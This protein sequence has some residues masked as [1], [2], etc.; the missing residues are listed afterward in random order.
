MKLPL[1]KPLKVDEKEIT[2]LLF[3]FDKL[4]G[5]DI[6]NATDEA[7]QIKGYS[8]NEMQT[9]TFRAVLAAKAC[10]ILYHDLLKLGARDFFRVVT[11]SH[12]FLVGMD[13]KEMEE[14]E[15][16]EE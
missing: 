12:A 9:P 7:R 5:A 4:T 13:L 16:T 8:P 10:G 11:A 15:E 6:M 2:T 3:D 1:E 14:I